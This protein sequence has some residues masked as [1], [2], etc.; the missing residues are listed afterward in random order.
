MGRGGAGARVSA[1]KLRPFTEA[2]VDA[3]TAL[4]ASC[5]G[6]GHGPGDD[7]ASIARFLRRN[8]GLSFVAESAEDGA[9]GDGTLVGA[10]LCGHDGRRGFLYRLAVAPALRRSGLARALV[11]A[12]LAGLAA[13]GIPRAMVFVLV[14]NAAALGFWRAVGAK[15]RAELGLLS[16]D[17]EV[18]RER[19]GR[20]TS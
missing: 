4:W 15:D 10:V 14:D 16:I 13:E 19:D 9:G 18:D 11:D 20:S 2:D 12:G 6:L 3:V 8:P 17:V 7:A 5:E 1:P